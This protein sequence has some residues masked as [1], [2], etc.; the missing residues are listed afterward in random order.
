MIGPEIGK[1]S[2]GL[3][4]R[5][6]NVCP[7]SIEKDWKFADGRGWVVDSEVTLKCIEKASGILIRPLWSMNYFDGENFCFY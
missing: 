3:A 6:D 5:G 7:E 1:F 4:N 2:G